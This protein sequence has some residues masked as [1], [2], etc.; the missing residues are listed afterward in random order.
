MVASRRVFC[1]TPLVAAL[2]VVAAFCAVA[3]ALALL[4]GAMA[5]LAVSIGAVA[6]ALG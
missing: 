2:R 6:G 5:G 1:G 3:L 4:P